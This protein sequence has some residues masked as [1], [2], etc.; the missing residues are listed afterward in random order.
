MSDDIRKCEFCQTRQVRRPKDVRCKF[1][2]RCLL[3]RRELS[4][5]LPRGTSRAVHAA[6]LQG[7]TP[8]D[9]RRMGTA[10]YEPAATVERRLAQA[11]AARLAEERRQG[12]RRYTI[13]TGWMQRPGAG[14]FDGVNGIWSSDGESWA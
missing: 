2:R 3:L 9:L 11:R 13:E 5:G 10:P 4:R 12:R 1:C 8:T 7:E 6:T 14:Q